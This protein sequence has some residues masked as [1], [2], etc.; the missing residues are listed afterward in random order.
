MMSISASSARL[1]TF[2]SPRSVK[3][4]PVESRNLPP[5]ERSGS[6]SQSSGSARP[7]REIQARG[8]PLESPNFSPDTLPLEC[9]EMEPDR[10]PE[11]ASRY[12]AATLAAAE[13]V[14]E[15]FALNAPGVKRRGACL[16][17]MPVLGCSTKGRR[18]GE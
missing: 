1:P 11:D 12:E 9:E 14:P 13:A 7:G 8:S 2:I 18:E 17:C 16:L 4:V 5:D 15:L 6:C 3:M 10:S